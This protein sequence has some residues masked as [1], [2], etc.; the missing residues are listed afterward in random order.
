MTTQIVVVVVNWN[1]MP[2][3]KGHGVRHPNN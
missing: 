1:G 3:H 2:I